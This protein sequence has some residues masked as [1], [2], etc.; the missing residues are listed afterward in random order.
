[1]SNNVLLTEA[2][3][4]LENNEFLK[5]AETFVKAGEN[6]QA[7]F[8]YLLTGN[9]FETQKLWFSYCPDS[10]ALQ[11]G[12]C[13]LD[14]INLRPR[15]R[16]PSY[17]Q[18]RNFLEMDIGYFIKANKFNY[19]ENVI[20][21][22]EVLISV[23]LEAYKL[24]GRVLLSFGYY[25]QAKTYL[26]KSVD[27]INQDPETYYYL[28]MLDYLT[29]A[30]KDCIKVLQKSLELNCYYVPASHLIEKAQLKMNSR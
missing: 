13:M 15:P 17:L 29:G 7:G 28:G 18:I 26:K 4:Y 1:M 19:A 23:N 12:K 8:C 9:D 20:K 16:V 25:N 22:S 24:I 11:W 30:Y 3:S 10:P 21:N 5:A 27:V 14:F 2:L 6:Y